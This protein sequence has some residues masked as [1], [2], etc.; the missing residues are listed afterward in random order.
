MNCAWDAFVQLLPIRF[1]RE[2]DK[3]G[4]E[5]LLEVRLRLGAP[6]DLVL[7][8]RSISLK[9]IVT[10]E[11]L[12]HCIQ[13]A[14]QYSPWASGTLNQG[15]LTAPGGHRIGVFG[16]YAPHRDCGWVLQTPAM[17]C[18]RVARNIMDI[19]PDPSCTNGSVLII[20]P[21]GVG[22][23]TLLRDLIRKY[24]NS[25][26]GNISVID[27]REELFPRFQDRLCFETGQKT[28]VLSGCKKKIGIQWALRNMTP[29]VIAVD[30]ITDPE[31]CQAL[32]HAAWC[33]TTLFATAHAGNKN[34][35]MTR[36]VYRPILEH[37]LFQSLL[38]MQPDKTWRMER[39]NI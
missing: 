19:A 33:G 7:K 26:M 13:F 23:T 5:Y 2:V 29:S 31:D 15:Y 39:M 22:K 21:P 24:A 12:A 32:L 16:K 18:L 20:G 10:S 4:K 8:D 3:L 14:S 34:D 1:R 36:P 17:L 30:E 11:D 37:N 35:L 38:V 9:H 28:D 27:E 6:P 25:G